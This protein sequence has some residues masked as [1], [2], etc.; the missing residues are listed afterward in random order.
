MIPKEN[1]EKVIIDREKFLLA[2]K[3]ASL[4]TSQ[5]SQAVKI[6]VEKGKMVISKHSPDIGE[7]REEMDVDYK[8]PAF[9]IGFNPAYLIDVLKNLN[10][11][12]IAFE[13]QN[14][15]KPGVIRTKDK[16]IYVV[17]PMQLT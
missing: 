15:E 9:S 16:Y 10:E 1:K 11:Q 8:G 17:L 7:A 6:D 2:A 4:L 3:R 14:P 12:S 13:L 5:D